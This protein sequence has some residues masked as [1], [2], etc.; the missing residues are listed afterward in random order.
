MRFAGQSAF[1]HDDDT[2]GQRE[3]G[4]GDLRDAP[5]VVDRAEATA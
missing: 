1:L 3:R 4:T 5:A 2:V